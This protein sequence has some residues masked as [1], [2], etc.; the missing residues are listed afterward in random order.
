MP[1]LGVQA[2]YPLANQFVADS[3][4][5]SQI[6]GVVTERSIQKRLSEVYSGQT[7]PEG[8]GKHVLETL[9]SMAWNIPITPR[10]R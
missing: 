8:H 3:C 6:N 7:G 1:Q 9:K 2:Q 10:W 5:K 4:P